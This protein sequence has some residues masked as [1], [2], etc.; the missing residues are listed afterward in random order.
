MTKTCEIVEYL[1]S[2]TE[3]EWCDSE[4]ELLQQEWS[5]L[6]YT[7]ALRWIATAN[8]PDWVVVHGTVESDKVGKR[9]EHA[10]C[11][12]GDVVVDLVQP[13]GSKIIN[14]RRY[15]EDVKPEVH[16]MYPAM[17]AVVL[18]MQN[19]IHGPWHASGGING[20]TAA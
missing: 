17:D 19:G 5:Q 1:E 3:A 15:Y 4:E 7:A 2:V 11:E 18:A 8:D 9:I 16:N 14:R 20:E 13:A 12:R 6:C 10:W